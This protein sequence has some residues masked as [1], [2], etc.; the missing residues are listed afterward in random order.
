MVDKHEFI[1]VRDEGS[2]RRIILNRPEVLNAFNEPTLVALLEALR[3]A[4]E[5]DAIRCLV[6]TGAGRA[7]S[8]GQD[9]AVVG[10]RYAAGRRMQFDRLLRD[11][12]NPIITSI[13]TMEKPIVAS[14]N[15]VAAGAGCSLALACDLRIAAE[16]ASF[17][18]AFINV[19]LVPDAGSSYML[20]RL[21]GV[22]RAMDMAF[23]GRRVSAA[24]ALEIGLVNY[25][26]ADDALPVET[27]TLAQRLASMP[28]RAIGLAKRAINAA[29]NADLPAQLDREALLQGQAEQTQ[30]HSEGIAAFTQKRTP[31]FQGR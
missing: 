20:P 10:E 8:S 25:V 30:D 21:I 7:F 16:S 15:G 29:F 9:L 14:V 18:Q 19:G 1:L 24:E 2:V 23:T 26:V 13:R 6:V 22:S 4:E 5:D 12:Y 31:N 17:I 27:T 28:T 3:E 11:R